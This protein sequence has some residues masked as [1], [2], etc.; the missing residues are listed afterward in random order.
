M[1]RLVKNKNLNYWLCGLIFVI[2]FPIAI[3][4]AGVVR[5]IPLL[6]WLAYLAVMPYVTG[7]LVDYVS[8]KWMD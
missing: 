1:G 4:I 7:R 5:V 6:G 2:I 8:D 3:S